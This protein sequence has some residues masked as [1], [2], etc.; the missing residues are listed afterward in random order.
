[1]PLDYFLYS[2]KTTNLIC[3]R[4]MNGRTLKNSRAFSCSFMML[5][6]QLNLEELLLTEFCQ[7]WTFY[8]S[9]L[10]KARI[11]IRMIYLWVLVVIQDGQSL[12]SI[13]AWQRDLLCILLL[14]YYVHRISGT[15]LI[16]IGLQNG[17]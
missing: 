15:T 14:W 12:K 13:T 3:Y 16:V 2:I 6:Y 10:K 7:Q 17:F 8:L 1:M 9:N 5:H 11:S 4:L